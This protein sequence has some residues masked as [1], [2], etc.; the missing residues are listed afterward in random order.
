MK[1]RLESKKKTVISIY[2]VTEDNIFQIN[3]KLHRDHLDNKQEE[4]NMIYIGR[5]EGSHSFK[6]KELNYRTGYKNG[7]GIMFF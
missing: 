2:R 7:C 4:N 6:I 3:N 1:T 5:N